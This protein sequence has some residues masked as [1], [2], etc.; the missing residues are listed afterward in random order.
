VN[1]TRP[2]TGQGASQY[3][4]FISWEPAVGGVLVSDAMALTGA[5]SP[6]A[7]VMLNVVPPVAAVSPSVAIDL[8]S[9][10]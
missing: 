1:G 4:D 9:A 6:A 10:K 2:A 5:G 8:L 7:S 3:S